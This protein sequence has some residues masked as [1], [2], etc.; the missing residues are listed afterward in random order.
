VNGDDSS[1]YD[2]AGGNMPG[3]DVAL[4]DP[5]ALTY[6]GYGI[7]DYT[8]VTNQQVDQGDGLNWPTMNDLLAKLGSR[9]G[10]AGGS[11]GPGAGFNPFQKTAGRPM[12]QPNQ[13]MIAPG[14]SSNVGLMQ[15]VRAILAFASSR[16]GSRLSLA[17]VIGLVRFVGP[18]A[19]AIALGLTIAEIYTLLTAQ[20]IKRGRRRRGRGITARQ[21][22]TA[23]RTIRKMTTFMSMVQGACAPVIGGARRSRGRHRAG[24]AC[25]VC[26]RAA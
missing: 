15:T 21:I 1:F 9:G 26:R 8:G 2:F 23:R 19:A 5:T 22:T 11:M 20:T 18:A 16:V 3:T 14:V 17:N 24:C 6:G 25:A 12:F 10:G 4:A 7:D 13:P